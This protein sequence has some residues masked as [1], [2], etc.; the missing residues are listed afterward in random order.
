ML[1]GAAKFFFD[2]TPA[3]HKS[4]HHLTSS[5]A[6]GKLTK[7]IYVGNGKYVRVLT[8]NEWQQKHNNTQS[9]INYINTTK[10]HT[11]HCVVRL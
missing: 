11:R 9:H 5:L 4:M 8:V 1:K 3:R 6:T 7:E 10:E 2:L